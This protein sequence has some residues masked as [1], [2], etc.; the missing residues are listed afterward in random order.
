MIH[1]HR[2]MESTRCGNAGRQPRPRRR[3]PI[4][5]SSFAILPPTSTH[6]ALLAVRSAFDL[7]PAPPKPHKNSA[8]MVYAVKDLVSVHP[9]IRL[10][11]FASGIRRNQCAN[12][13][14]RRVQKPKRA[15]RRIGVKLIGCLLLRLRARRAAEV[16][17]CAY[18]HTQN[19]NTQEPPI[20]VRECT[21]TKNYSEIAK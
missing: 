21:N 19:T 11:S 12:P 17:V 18:V 16:Q 8:T 5:N 9:S 2:R 7:L 13:C 1:R 4:L 6:L 14:R 3:V 15:R 20:C 10:P